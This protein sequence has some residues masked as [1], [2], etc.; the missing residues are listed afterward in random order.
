MQYLYAD[1]DNHVFM[2]NESF[3]Q[4]E[5]SSDYL[6]EELN[7]LKEGMEVQI[8]TYEG[9]TIGVELPKTVELTVTE[10][11]PVLKVILQLVLLNRQLL[12]QVIH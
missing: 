10:T 6:K 9:E 2:D 3:E 4:T 12:K 5:L 8:Q 7:Y 11:E 1:G